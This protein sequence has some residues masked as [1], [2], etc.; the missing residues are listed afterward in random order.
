MNIFRLI[1]DMLHLLSIITLLLKIHATKSCRGEA[2]GMRSF[3]PEPLNCHILCV[4]CEHDKHC[5]HCRAGISFK[6][7]ELYTLVFITR[8]LDLFF[9]YISLWVSP[10]SWTVVHLSLQYV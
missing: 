10:H 2:A 7:Q 3:H 1:G 9:R 8:Y 5:C 4:S 6:T